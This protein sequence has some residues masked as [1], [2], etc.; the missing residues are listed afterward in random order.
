MIFI[1]ITSAK[2]RCSGQSTEKAPVKLDLLDR[3]ESAI[4]F[5]GG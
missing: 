3:I 4:G 2:S 1:V 5:S